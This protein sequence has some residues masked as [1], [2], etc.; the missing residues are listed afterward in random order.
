MVL[1]VFPGSWAQVRDIVREDNNS[2]RPTPFLGNLLESLE[3]FRTPTDLS[4]LIS[5][6]S[7]AQGLSLMVSK[8]EEA[9][10]RLHPSYSCGSGVMGDN[11]SPFSVWWEC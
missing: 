5:G 9:D 1:L 7:S 8:T 4:S 6:L 10:R 11:H 3:A 2:P